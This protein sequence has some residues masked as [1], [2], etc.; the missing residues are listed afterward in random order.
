MKVNNKKRDY[1]TIKRASF[2]A[3]CFGS[4]TTAAYLSI[5]I[6]TPDNGQLVLAGASLINAVYFFYQAIK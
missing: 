6:T 4:F 1:T 3:M 5:L 2:I